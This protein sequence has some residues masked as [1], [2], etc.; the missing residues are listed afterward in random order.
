MKRKQKE[1]K[2]SGEEKR[3]ESIVVLDDSKKKKKIG[4]NTLLKLK[5]LAFP[6]IKCHSNSFLKQKSHFST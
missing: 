6:L 5:F 1:M 3:K 4:R 2:G